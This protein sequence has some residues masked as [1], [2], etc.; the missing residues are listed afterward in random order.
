MTHRTQSNRENSMAPLRAEITEWDLRW[1]HAPAVRSRNGISYLT[2][3][4]FS[5]QNRLGSIQAIKRLKASA[6]D[7]ESTWW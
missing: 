3:R 1:P 4:R 7:R 5:A 2:A 6:T